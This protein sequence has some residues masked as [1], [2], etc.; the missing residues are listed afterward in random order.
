MK[1]LLKIFVLL[2][3]FG[4]FT[5]DLALSE[6]V[7]SEKSLKVAVVNF[8][9]LV[10]ES[11]IGKKYL[12]SAKSNIEK[13]QKI[14]SKL[15]DQVRSMRDKYDEQK[16]V[17]DEKARDEKGED[18]AYKIT[19]LRRKREDFESEIKIQEKYSKRIVSKIFSKIPK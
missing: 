3:S 10:V 7:K 16:L 8:Q 1:L 9:R 13:K 2:I 6:E 19:E 4:I 11:N 14:L 17:L 5:S 15:E 18:L 12:K